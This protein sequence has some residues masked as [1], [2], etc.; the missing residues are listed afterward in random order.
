M[1]LQC[2]GKPTAG[3]N[4][5]QIPVLVCYHTAMDWELLQ[6]AEAVGRVLKARGDMLVSAESCTGGWIGH[7]ITAV[8]GSSHWYERGFITYT[9]QSKQDMLGV[10]ADTLEHAGAVS[11]ATVREMAEGALDHSPAQVSIAVSGIA[12]PGGGSEDKPVGTVCFAWAATG[13]ETL[14]VVEHFAGDREAV[15]RQATAHALKGLLDY[16]GEVD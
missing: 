12:G 7:A 10:S 3:E 9:N 15:R 16:L 6:L 11:E 1:D 4:R 5:A 2:T 14:S 13:G 8:P